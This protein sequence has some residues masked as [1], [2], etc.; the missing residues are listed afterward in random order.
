MPDLIREA[1]ALAAEGLNEEALSLYREAVRKDPDGERGYCGMAAMLLRAR[2]Y[3]EAAGC[4][5]ELMRLRPGSAYPHGVLGVARNLAG[6]KDDALACF[7]KMTELDPDDMMA[8]LSAVVLLASSGRKKE[9]EAAFRQLLDARPSGPLAAAEQLLAVAALRGG[10]KRG[11]DASALMPGMAELN[12]VL[13]SSDGRGGPEALLTRAAEVERLGMRR[14]AAAMIDAA[15][16][17]YPGSAQAHR[18]KSAA[19][20]GDGRSAEALASLDEALRLGPGSAGDLLTKGR[21]LSGLGRA[22]E[23]LACYERAISLDPGELIAYHLKCRLLALAGDAQGL[24]ECYRA[25][26]AAEPSDGYRRGV[27]ERMRAEYAELERWT[28]AA[29]SEKLGLEAFVEKSGVGGRPPPD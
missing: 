4:A 6:R 27:Q 16:A 13:S 3:D 29:G 10:V 15:L 11:S 8:R 26:L 22:G 28:K 18:A 7:Q 19:L 23:A 5:E 14:E 12:E 17:A 2:R 21:L 1:N 9:A 20:D 25:A 24:A